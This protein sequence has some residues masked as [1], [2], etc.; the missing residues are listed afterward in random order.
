MRMMILH[1]TTPLSSKMSTFLVKTAITKNHAVNLLIDKHVVS[2]QELLE[3]KERVKQSGVLWHG[4]PYM[5]G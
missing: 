5:N 2:L 3:T 4:H 1:N